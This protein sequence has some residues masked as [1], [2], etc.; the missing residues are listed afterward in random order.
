[1]AGV[2]CSSTKLWLVFWHLHPTGGFLNRW[3]PHPVF[4]QSEFQGESGS[5]RCER[6]S[7]HGPLEG[8]LGALE[9]EMTELA[10]VIDIYS[11]SVLY[12]SYWIILKHVSIY[13][14]L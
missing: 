5:G 12:R 13:D 9:L 14:R 3:F 1:M 2:D 7:R 6:K 11:N 10:F 8:R 4:V